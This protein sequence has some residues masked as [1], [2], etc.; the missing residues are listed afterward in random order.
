VQNRAGRRHTADPQQRLEQHAARLALSER[1]G[2]GIEAPIIHD[3]NPRRAHP[4]AVMVRCLLCPAA[5]RSI[6]N[7]ASNVYKPTALHEATVDG[8][9]ERRED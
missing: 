2:Q 5:D 6:A 1:A 4:A 9:L 7:H 3:P 8:Y